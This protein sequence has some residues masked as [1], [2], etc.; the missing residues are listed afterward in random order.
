MNVSKP[1]VSV[2]VMTY[3]HARYI[4]ECLD[5]I[6]MQKTDFPFEICLGEDESIDGTR[7]ICKE[8]AEKYSD[9]IRLFLRSRKDVIYMN[10]FAT[11]RFNFTETLKACKGKYIALCEGDD[12]WTD[13]LKLQKQVDFLEKNSGYSICFHNVKVLKDSEFNNDYLTWK[14]PETTTLNCLINGNYIHT[15]SC[16][17]RNNFGGNPL[18]DIL[19]K[20]PLG[21]YAL[22]IINAQY[23]KI[24][25]L[26]DCMAVYRI[27]SCSIFSSKTVLEN[28]LSVLTT[29]DRLIEFFDKNE[30]Y[31]NNLINKKL[32]Y[33]KNFSKVIFDSFLYIYPEKK[34]RKTV[35]ILNNLSISEEEKKHPD[36][37]FHL[38]NNGMPN[39]YKK[40]C[41]VPMKKPSI[42]VLHRITYNIDDGKLKTYN[43]KEIFSNGSVQRKKPLLIYF[44]T[45]IPR[46]N[47]KFDK[48]P[49]TL[50]IE[51]EINPMPDSFFE[52]SVYYNF[53]LKYFKLKDIFL[54]Q[55]S[56]RMKILN[57]I[58]EF[59]NRLKTIK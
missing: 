53:M 8:Y 56:F 33:L 20:S 46:V 39:L 1:F 13:P 5:G 3:Q 48:A 27:H 25:K 42:L 47:L 45:P 6:L 7:E 32:N 49:Q 29:L 11:G 9:K 54:P 12:Y 24:K 36:F 30:L 17:F 31:K 55:K 22:H 38:G 59:F 34:N 51:C 44:Y 26:D 16:V 18:P 10:G 57:R 21:D 43:L 2:A 19:Y 37:V 15:V 23:G 4:R 52:E 40:F 28:S 58:L 41:W 14:V 35:R 50:K